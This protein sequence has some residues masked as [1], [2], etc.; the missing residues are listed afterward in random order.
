MSSILKMLDIPKSKIRDNRYFM[1]AGQMTI[2]SGA[3]FATLTLLATD[4]MAEGKSTTALARIAAT[5]NITIGHRQGELP[6]SYVVENQVVGYTTDICLKIVDEVKEHLKLDNLK[7]TYVPVT[8]ATRFVYIKSGRIDLECAATTNTAER[9]QLAEFAFPHFVTATR[10]VTRKSDGIKS[11]KD[12][13]GRS[14]AA[15]TGTINVEQLNALNRSMNLNISVLLNKEHKDA[16]TQ[17]ESGKASAFVMDDI[18][19]AGLVASAAIPSDF[20]ISDESL[21]RPEPYGIM[22]PP[23]DLEFKAIV[24]NALSK[25]YTG[26]EIVQIYDKWFIS[27]VPPAGTNMNLPMSPELRAAFA[28]PQEYLD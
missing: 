7:I 10:F 6:F 12:L 24:N 2:L 3:L 27:P 17:V 15:T 23:G 26:G 14:V 28:S 5:Q 1:T 21:S 8:A 19:L 25:I 11:I 20:V 18:L 9:R 13:A 4:T 16:F 22:M